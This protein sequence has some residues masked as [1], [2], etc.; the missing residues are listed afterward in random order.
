MTK[1]LF[2]SRKGGT[3]KSTLCAM[4]ANHLALLGKTIAVIDCDNCNTLTWKRKSDKKPL[5]ENEISPYQIF[6]SDEYF[7]KE[8]EFEDSDYILFDSFASFTEIN[9]DFI[10][11]PFIYSE[12]V[13]DSTFKFIKDLRTTGHEKIMFVPNEVNGYKQA[14]KKKDTIET[15]NWILG[16]F[17]KIM[18][19]VSYNRVMEQVS[20]ISNTK[21]QNLLIKD[22]VDELLPPDCSMQE[23]EIVQS[24]DEEEG[25][26]M[27][28]SNETDSSPMKDKEE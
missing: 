16:I 14:L 1:I 6:L 10:V 13:L 8:K 2:A 15:I 11:I 24:V 7:G 9:V 5:S 27:I 20:T 21:E 17:G 4:V 19:K 3:G 23:R 18:P 12:M 28:S 25:K 22:F 26:E